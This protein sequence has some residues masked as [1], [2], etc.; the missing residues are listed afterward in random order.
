M[1]E[2]VVW[3]RG[4]VTDQEGQKNPKTEGEREMSA[5]GEGKETS[6]EDQGMEQE[7]GE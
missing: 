6:K 2:K 3:G 1:W 4:G 5:E 7:K